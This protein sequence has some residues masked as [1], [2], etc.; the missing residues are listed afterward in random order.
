MNCDGC[1]E[2]LYKTIVCTNCGLVS[3]ELDIRG[4]LPPL[5][6]NNNKTLKKY[7]LIFTGPL[8]PDMEY[9][10]RY[11]RKSSNSELNR[12]LSWQKKERNK[13]EKKKYFRDYKDIERICKYLQVPKTVLYEALNIRKQIGKTGNYFDRKTY[14]KNIACVKIAMRIC[15]FPVNEK[16]FIQLMKNY[17]IIER[18]E[19]VRLRGNEIKREIDKKYTEIMYKYLKINIPSPESPNFI[20]YACEKLKIPLRKYELYTKYAEC[21]DKFNPSC[22]IQGYVLAL[23]HILYAK[24]DKIKI[25][26]MEEEFGVN[27]L[28]ISSRKKELMRMLK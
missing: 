12:A 3:E 6:Y 24:S 19:G 14:Y 16:D 28:T 27:R 4:N 25:I 7:N 8:S 5:T 17:P 21:R 23:I 1:G 15:D 18:G 26:T 20:S 22:S 2:E 11:A 10:H 13:T 9:L